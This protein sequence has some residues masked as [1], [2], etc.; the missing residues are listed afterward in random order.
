MTI[1]LDKSTKY[2]KV[3]DLAVLIRNG[4]WSLKLRLSSAEIPSLPTRL[5]FFLLVSLTRLANMQIKQSI[6]IYDAIM[7]KSRVAQKKN[8]VAKSSKLKTKR[9][10]TY[11]M[12]NE[13]IQSVELCSEC[14][15][16]R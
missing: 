1:F 2:K 9:K 12:Y 8:G 10:L 13:P 7:R 14:K 5:F 11:R 3:K 15:L 6:T 4:K 16:V